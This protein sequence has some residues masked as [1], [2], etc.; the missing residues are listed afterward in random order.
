MRQRI[1][2][3]A[4]VL[5]GPTLAQTGQAILQHQPLPHPLLVLIEDLFPR[6][7]ARA[8]FRALWA[9]HES[10]PPDPVAVA[11]HFRDFLAAA[12]H[13]RGRLKPPYALVV[14]CSE[15]R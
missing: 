13:A 5:K 6:D 8:R 4:V 12:F 3:L 10:E 9:E 1:V 14:D 7:V 11:G 15:L 2:D